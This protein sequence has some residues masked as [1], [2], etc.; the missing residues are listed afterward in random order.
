MEYYDQLLVGRKTAERLMNNIKP[1]YATFQ[2]FIKISNLLLGNENV[3]TIFEFGARYAEDTLEFAKE[4]KHAT[5]YTF[6]C[7]PNTL[8]ECK[9]Q[10]SKYPNIILTEK[11]VTDNDGTVT[12][13][14][15]DKENTIT[16]W[17]DGN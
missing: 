11:A 15:I 17:E 6:E 12:F 7:N 2:K 9:K 14:A 10:V 8:S 16:T 5:V 4:F 13:Y 1:S 3:N